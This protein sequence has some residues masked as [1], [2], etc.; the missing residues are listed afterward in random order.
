MLNQQHYQSS[1]EGLQN[2]SQTSQSSYPQT[3]LIPTTVKSPPHSH[4]SNPLHIYGIGHNKDSQQIV[5]GPIPTA[6]TVKPLTSNATTAA[7]A[8]RKST[9]SQTIRSVTPP[10]INSNSPSRTA[11][12]L[13]RK[14]VNYNDLKTADKN[15]NLK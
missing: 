4:T 5:S 15:T 7:H 6:T 12:K 13:N 14:V 2:F 1:D 10:N 8:S 3:I 11:P 9:N